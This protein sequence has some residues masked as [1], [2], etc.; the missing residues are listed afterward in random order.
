MKQFLAM[1]L[2]LI[3]SSSSAGAQ[4]QSPFTYE[5][6]Q[7]TFSQ[8][9]STPGFD[10]TKP[11]VWGYFFT[12]KKADNLMPARAKLVSDGYDFIRL[13]EDENGLWWL[14][15]SR[16][17]VHSPESLHVRNT[18]LF[19]YAVTLDGVDYDGWDVTRSPD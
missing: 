9:E 14:E 16:A 19:N 6:L 3:G 4:A 15:L 11:L 2:S 12:A 1:L 8:M 17:E 13:E 10:V 18:E 7:S 5:K